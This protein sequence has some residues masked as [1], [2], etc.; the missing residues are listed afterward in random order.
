MLS[1]RPGSSL[2]ELL[3]QIKSELHNQKLKK[4]HLSFINKDVV[5]SLDS[6]DSLKNFLELPAKK[7]IVR[8]ARF[9][10]VSSANLAIAKKIE[11]REEEGRAVIT[12]ERKKTIGEIWT[13]MQECELNAF[14][15]FK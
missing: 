14:Q 11:E 12:S 1:L 5:V 10:P 2:E 4:Q 8:C 7:R 3:E 15:A 6:E 9:K 13:V